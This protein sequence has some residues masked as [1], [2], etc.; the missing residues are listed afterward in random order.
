M[1]IRLTGSSFPPN[2]F[3]EVMTTSGSFFNR[4]GRS[5][6]IAS[7]RAAGLFLALAAS[8][9]GASGQTNSAWLPIPM[10]SQAQLDARVWPGG[11]GCQYPQMIAVDSQDG[12]FVLY[13]TD[14][15]GM[16]RSTNGG[17]V[18]QP[19]NVGVGTAGAVG[20]AID[21]RN[22]LRCLEV[23][24][25]GGNVYNI[26]GGVNLSTNQGA[27]WTS[28]CSKWLDALGHGYWAS[29]KGRE[30]I[31]YDPSSY[32]PSL[33]YC[34]VAYW[35][36]EGN[37]QEARGALYKSSDGGAS[38]AAKATADKYG[39]DDNAH[40]L[41]KVHPTLGYIYIANQSG[42]SGT[43][44]SGL[45]RSTNGGASFSRILAGN[46][47]SLEVVPSAPNLV[48]TAS[49]ST[50]YLSTNSGATFTGFPAS[51]IGSLLA[52]KVSPVNP[53]NLLASDAN[54]NRKRFFSSNGGTNW[55][56]CG[57]NLG[58][59]WFPS[60][61][62]YDDRNTAHAWH[63]TNGAA[64]W[65]IGPGDIISATTNGGA[66]L[67]WAN[68]G[69]N[70]I[71]LGGGFNFNAR[72]PDIL[73][74]GSQDYNGALTTNGGRTWLFINLS[75]SGSDPDPWGWVYGAY[76]ADA[77]LLF[78]G[79]HSYSDS[80]MYLWLTANQ[81]AASSQKVSTALTGLQTSYGDPTDTNV[82][83][84]WNFRSANHGVNWSP[85]TGCQGVFTCDFSNHILYGASATAVVQSTNQGLSWNVVATLN[86]NVTDAA[87]DPV[88]KRLLVTT[89]GAL[90]RCDPPVYVPVAITQPNGSA[91][92]V[93]LDPQDARIIYVAGTPGTWR[94]SDNTVVRSLD[95][96]TSW[97]KLNNRADLGY[98]GANCARW[99]RVH[100]VTR[101]LWVG[102]VCY[103]FWRLGTRPGINSGPTAQVIKEGQNAVFTV[104]ASG[105]APL[106]YQ[107]Q[108][109]GTNLPGATFSAYTRS[110]AVPLNAG[111]YSVIVSNLAATVTS[112]AA[113]LVVAPN[114][115]WGDSVA[116]APDGVVQ[117]SIRGS[118]AGM[119]GLE[120][121]ADLLSWGEL[122]NVLLPIPGFH[123]MD[124]APNLPRRYYRAWRQ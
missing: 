50:V 90:W 108:F 91:N 41:I 55:L 54:A 72:N 31:A 76:A 32:N 12:S 116:V 78:G 101:E 16:Y 119:Y 2:I 42:A 34:T 10:V 20:F 104:N 66:T 70:G 43:N 48:W 28:V 5:S 112:A 29:G 122:T 18:F 59:S 15:G 68:N 111:N 85:M 3:Y 103:G 17:K 64:A 96:G 75:I 121:S 61:I 11:E 102:T 39:G 118:S 89:G 115:P 13:G 60:S 124:P 26:Y 19:C 38:W 92:S 79:N 109:A 1:R 30:Q 83:F 93:A 40:S 82:L 65:C 22:K 9:V 88:S 23:G 58:L 57:L 120:A 4:I 33:G 35:V 63:P 94:K 25:G 7:I 106:F 49:G 56:P 73:Y 77:N 21:P 44:Q 36:E 71:M 87:I 53:L 86:A 95:G 97:E 100:P 105:S 123:Y 51:G 45:Y 110:N 98:D 69:N 81:G 99:C 46:F 24:D 8:A 107:W 67:N 27:T 74:F 117:L 52:L 37:P 47:P 6:A 80:T 114:P 84:C 113:A 14:V 62:L